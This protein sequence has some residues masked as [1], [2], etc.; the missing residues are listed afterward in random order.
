MQPESVVTYGADGPVGSGS[1]VADLARRAKAAAP[2]LAVATT[3]VKN[4]AL[5]AAADR[6]QADV[7]DLL[8]ANAEDIARGEAEGMP[9]GMVDR[10]R[11]DE[12]R[13]ASG[14]RPGR[15]GWPGD[16]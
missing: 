11:L 7:A 4:V 2:S 6:L 15:P 14:G 12:V 8:D 5:L 13:A 10:L 16:V 3:E 1:G 9:A